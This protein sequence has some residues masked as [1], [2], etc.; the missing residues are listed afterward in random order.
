MS[1]SLSLD[2]KRNFTL[3][4]GARI[5]DRGVARSPPVPTAVRGR[6]RA[7]MDVASFEHED[8]E[9]MRPYKVAG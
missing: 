1:F 4:R 8:N 2:G 5:E 3:R 9:M 7:R 6:H